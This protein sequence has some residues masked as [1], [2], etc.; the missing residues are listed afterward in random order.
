MR[1]VY[2]VFWIPT[3]I[4]KD[5][6]PIT[7]S[8]S[9][10]ISD[11]KSESLNSSV[12]IQDNKNL[13]IKINK[14][15]ELLEFIECNDYGFFMY[16]RQFDD[17]NNNKYLKEEL[18][19]CI[20]HQVKEL[21][22]KHKYHEPLEDSLLRVYFSE[23]PIDINDRN[24]PAITFYLNRYEK[25]FIN[26]L[27]EIRNLVLDNEEK[28]EGKPFAK[29]QVIKSFY[30]ILK[31]CTNAIGESIYCN[32]LLNIKPESFDDFNIINAI[33]DINVLKIKIENLRNYKANITSIIL[34][35][36]ATIIALI[37]V[38]LGIYGIAHSKKTNK[39]LK[40]KQQI[41]RIERQLN[42]A[43][44]DTDSLLNK[45]DSNTSY[46]ILSIHKIDSIIMNSEKKFQNMEK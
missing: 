12:E 7:N 30:S 21:Y 36:I 37:G 16:R 45:I 2:Y 3:V 25:K 33:K 24:N 6:V 15:Q 13:I 35:V 46:I 34:A 27:I 32:T 28:H 39:L 18:P 22:H 23:E 26:C 42:T 10:N 31:K 40:E 44:R 29:Y 8:V 11:D 38:F 4:R 43:I 19:T 20:Y 41:L 5:F 1:S 17:S 9:A 14:Q